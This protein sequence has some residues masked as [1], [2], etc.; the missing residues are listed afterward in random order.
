MVVRNGTVKHRRETSRRSVGP[1]TGVTTMDE[2]RT[3][4]VAI[5]FLILVLF[6]R[7]KSC[8]SCC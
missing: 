5:R 2:S 6:L 7:A 8:R 1:L 4:I 3:V